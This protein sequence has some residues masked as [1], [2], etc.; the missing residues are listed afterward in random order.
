MFF[1]SPAFNV[2]CAVWGLVLCACACAN[3]HD[4]Q[5]NRATLVQRDSHLVSMTLYI[6]M[7][8]AMHRV[9]APERPF[10]EFALAYANLPLVAFKSA[11]LQITSHMQSQTRASTAGGRQQGF[12]RWVW[13]EPQQIQ[14]ALRERLMEA[15][16]APGKHSQAA[17]LEVRAQ[18][19]AVRPIRALRVQFPA[20][21]GRVTVVSYRPKQIFAE[22]QQLS[23]I[24]LF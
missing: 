22:P 4:L 19:H 21:L 17:P 10:Q 15:V 23:P 20:A 6:A 2:A 11:L 7:P 16:V 9:L 14:T 24:V 8:E 18:L 13:P 3:A 12:E 5:E 1:L